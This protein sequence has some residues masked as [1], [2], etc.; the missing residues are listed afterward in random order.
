MKPI[1]TFLTVLLFSLSSI[2]QNM[3][4]KFWSF[5]KSEYPTDAS[6]QKFVYDQQKKAYNYMTGVTDAELKRF[7]EKEYPDDY[8]MQTLFTISKKRIK[9]TWKALLTRS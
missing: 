3:D 9:H 4:A 8:S 2:A 1:L 6:M 7:A 5:A